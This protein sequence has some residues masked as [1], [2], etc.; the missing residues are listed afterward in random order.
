MNVLLSIKPRYIE[1]IIK[2][3]KKY[4]FRKSIFCKPVDRIWIYAS[5]PTKKIIGSFEVNKVMRDTPIN[6]W[7]T[8]NHH[9][10][11]SESEFFE[12]F[13]DSKFGFAIEIQ[14]FTPLETPI[15]PSTFS[16]TFVPPQSFRY[17]IDHFLKE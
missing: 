6:L 8:L 14:N 11:I 16:T 3:N 17:I 4:E 1:E 15:D 2:G 12:Y 10:G 9:A 13:S 5:R 7:N